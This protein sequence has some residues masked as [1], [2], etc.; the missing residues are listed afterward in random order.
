MKMRKVK[1][2]IPAKEVEMEVPVDMRIFSEILE[3]TRKHK[4]INAIKLLR[5]VT[6]YGLKESKEYIENLNT[7]KGE[8]LLKQLRI[9]SPEYFL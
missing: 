6:G 3:A 9:D 4:K 5:S 8:L 7:E 2:T 1:I